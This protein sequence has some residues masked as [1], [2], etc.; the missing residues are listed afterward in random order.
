MVSTDKYINLL[1]R[2]T[3]ERG[4]PVDKW[5]IAALI[6]S[7]GIRDIDAKEEWGAEDVFALAGRLHEHVDL[8]T[9]EEKK[10]EIEEEKLVQRVFLNYLKGML[11]A[12]P[13]VLQ[14]VA[15]VIVGVG[16]WS[17]VHFS[18]REATAIAF[19]TLLALASTGGIAQIIGRKG[20]F[21]LK[22][23][24]YLLASKVTKRFYILGLIL[25]AVFTL[26]LFF[27]N[28]FMNLFPI[29]MMKIALYYYVLL[30]I[31][32]LVFSI[33]YMLNDYF[34]IASIITFGILLV[35]I[36]FYKLEFGIYT[37]QIITMV[38]VIIVSNI[39]ALKKLRKLELISYA[40]GVVLP[41]AGTLFYTLYPFFLY[42]ISYFLF[43]IMDRLMAWTTS[44][45]Y[46][47]YFMWF[48]MPYEVGVDWALFT[49]VVTVAFV[50]VFIYELGI[51]SFQKIKKIKAYNVKDF[52]EHFLGIYRFAIV[53]FIFMG[54]F[55][56][57]ISFFTPLILAVKF[58][59]PYARV[60]FILVNQKVFW[61]AS[62]GYTFL[63]IALLNCVIF[64]AYSRHKFALNSIAIGTLSNLIIG[65]A[66]SRIIDYYYSVVG[67]SVGAFIF[68]IVSSRYAWHF[69]KKF[70][71]YY[72]SAF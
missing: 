26:F 32:F 24:E 18:L 33:F 5:E 42:G 39:V 1:N 6:E 56:I 43:L 40:E 8:V 15:M 66:F 12:I 10:V 35:Y 41:K 59:L 27:L 53:V 4:K 3:R 44:K 28:Y 47:P 68:A 22:F 45:G 16:I 23:G 36:L 20:L 34:S 54:I 13:M 11:F 7:N 48:N 19:G 30:S 17:Y 64:F 29:Y 57:V 52:N 72:Y 21:Y 2:I 70:H 71:Y 65:F 37:S 14:I 61:F 9:Y 51:L 46:M 55:S 50:E 38:I 67:L 25:V 63:S 62:I 31:I 69:F 49:F 60:F 58:K